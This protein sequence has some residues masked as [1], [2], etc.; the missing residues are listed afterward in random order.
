MPYPKITAFFMCF[1]L[2]ACAAQVSP[3]DAQMANNLCA[4]GKA[5]LGA[6]KNRDA[7]D[8]YLSA[9]L[10]D[11]NNPRAWNGLGVA[12]DL[13]GKRDEARDAYQ[14]AVNLAPNDLT[15]LNNLAHL[16]LETGDATAAVEL[17]Q[18]YADDPKATATLRQNL[19]AA[20]KAAAVKDTSGGDPYADLGSYPTEGMAQGHLREAQKLL[21]DSDVHF[22]LMSDVKVTG[23]TPVFTVK[24]VGK[25]P[26]DI[27]D[28]L[29]PKGFPC[30]TK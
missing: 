30:V 20:Q 4:Q 17:L 13:L 19:A 16:E 24:A 10:R 21:D 14:H 18:P 26:Q 8:M 23:G 27:C 25:P 11:A 28:E 7:R 22:S 12:D 2:A 6:G 29:N 15:A 3:E 5:L 1:A 9:T